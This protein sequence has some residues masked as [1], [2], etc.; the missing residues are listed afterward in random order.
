LALTSQAK[1]FWLCYTNRHFKKKVKSFFNFLGRTSKGVAS[2]WKR[3]KL[4]LNR[5][6]LVVGPCKKIQVRRPLTQ[7]ESKRRRSRQG[8]GY[9][10]ATAVAG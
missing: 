7:D 4:F 3:E 2:A 1:S 6:N 9:R 5:L 8:D 10:M